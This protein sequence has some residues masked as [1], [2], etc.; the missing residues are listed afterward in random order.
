M[1][2][3]DIKGL[4]DLVRLELADADIE[5]YQKDFEGILNYINTINDVSL[6]DY[7][8]QLRSVTT[9]TMRADDVSYESG[10]FTEDLLNAAPHR[11]GDYF[12][13]K[14]VL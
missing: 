6:D 5:S 3:E 8:D 12:K 2:K 4:A 11:E 10:Q 13:V 14:K 9:N 1:N 7:N